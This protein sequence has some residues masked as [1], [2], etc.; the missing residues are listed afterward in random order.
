MLTFGLVGWAGTALCVQ[1]LRTALITFGLVGWGTAV[2][3]G[4]DLDESTHGISLLPVYVLSFGFGGGVV[5]MFGADKVK[6]IRSIVAWVI[7]VAIVLSGSFFIASFVASREPVDWV[8]GVS[9]VGALFVMMTFALAITRMN[10]R[11]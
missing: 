5:S 2:I 11:K 1:Q 4:V 7:A 8:W 10:A 3:A 6:S 9:S